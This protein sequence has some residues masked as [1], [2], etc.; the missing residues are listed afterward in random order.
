MR[1]LKREFLEE[2]QWTL[3]SPEA[4]TK[5][6]RVIG[7]QTRF[8][9]PHIGRR[10]VAPSE[11][12]ELGI[13]LR[14]G[15]AIDIPSGGAHRI[16]NTGSQDPVFIEVEHGEDFGEDDIERLEDDYGRVR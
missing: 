5:D 2:F 11:W 6:H 13:S 16:T 4:T 15:Q 14:G 7:A 8:V 10:P 9:T 1:S 12:S 3:R